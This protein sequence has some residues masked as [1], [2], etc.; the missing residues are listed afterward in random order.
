MGKNQTYFRPLSQQFFDT[1]AADIMVGTDK[2]F[3]FISP[4]FYIS[5]TSSKRSQ[6][7]G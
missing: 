6:A 1:A 7:S 3:Q 2:Q 5:V 4:F